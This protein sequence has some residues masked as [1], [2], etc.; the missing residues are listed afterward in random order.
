MYNVS[1][2]KNNIKMVCIYWK[3]S[4]YA[5]FPKG[6]RHRSLFV[7]GCLFLNNQPLKRHISGSTRPTKMVHLSK[8]M[9]FCKG[10]E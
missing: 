10:F 3:I 9:A 4:A 7:N 1:V 5:C 2:I 8:F 6:V